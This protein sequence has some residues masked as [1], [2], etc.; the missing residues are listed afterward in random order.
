MAR[1]S[2]KDTERLKQL[3]EHLYLAD[4]QIIIKALAEKVGVTEKTLSKWA[5][6]GKW[7][8]KRTSLLTTKNNQ[9]SFL[10]GQLK[11]LNQAI[12]DRKDNPFASNKEADTIIKLTAGIK[13]LETE[14]SLG[15]IIQTAKEFIDYVS[16]SDYEKAKE[17][18]K[19]FDGFI[20]YKA[21]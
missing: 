8:D 10:Y 13:N 3:A 21:V 17:I 1:R 14:T 2:K 5:K 4:S 19:L 12:A 9:L 20:N 11:N 18:T 16:E 6:D 15:D 7:N